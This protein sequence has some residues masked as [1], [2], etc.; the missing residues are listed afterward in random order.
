[1]R[2][3]KAIEDSTG[4][5]SLVVWDE[6]LVSYMRR[7]YEKLEAGKLR[8]D[9]SALKEGSNPTEWE[10]C[11]VPTDTKVRCDMA[12]TGSGFCPYDEDPLICGQQRYL[13]TLNEVYDYWFSS[14]GFLD[15]TLK[16]VADQDTDLV[17]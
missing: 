9:I 10:G 7:G 3:F 17:V 1:M 13:V 8:E 11:I 14:K 16:V 4:V 2:V 15:G 12:C 5:L 6:K